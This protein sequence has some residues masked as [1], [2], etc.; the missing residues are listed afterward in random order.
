MD[1]CHFGK[2]HDTNEQLELT[3]YNKVSSLFFKEMRCHSTHCKGL[4]KYG[5]NNLQLQYPMFWIELDEPHEIVQLLDDS[6]ISMI[7]A[8]H[9]FLGKGRYIIKK[10]AICWSANKL[11]IDANSNLKCYRCRNSAISIRY[12]KGVIGY[13]CRWYTCYYNVLFQFSQKC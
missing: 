11:Y 9:V 1:P 3:Y 8:K 12:E 2:S 5:K 4:F 13:F 6:L 10:E 7:A